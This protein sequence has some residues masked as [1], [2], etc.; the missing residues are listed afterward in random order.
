[1]CLRFCILLVLTALFSFLSCDLQAGW[2]GSCTEFSLRHFEPR[3]SWRKR[4]GRGRTAKGVQDRIYTNDE[5]SERLEKLATRLLEP[6]RTT[7]TEH[8]HERVQELFKRKTYVAAPAGARKV[9][10][11]VKWLIL[12]QNVSLSVPDNTALAMQTTKPFWHS[13]LL[14]TWDLFRSVALPNLSIEIAQCLHD[15]V[16]TVR[17]DSQLAKMPR[18]VEPV[19]LPVFSLIQCRGF[20]DDIPLPVFEAGRP[21][22]RTIFSS[23]L[24]DWDVACALHGSSAISWAH[25]QSKAVFRGSSRKSLESTRITKKNGR[26]RMSV[27]GR[28]ALAQ[29]THRHSEIFDV[30]VIGSSTNCSGRGFMSV[31]EQTNFKYSIYAEG[32][33]GWADRLWWQMHTPQ[34]VL[35]Q[36]SLCGLFFEQLM[37]PFVDH[38]PCA[39]TFE[40]LPHRVKWLTRHDREALIITTNAM[41]FSEAFLVRRAIIEYFETLLK[42]YSEIWC[43]SAQLMGEAR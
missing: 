29:H 18:Y 5:I 20:S 19:P 35:K 10:G 28:E 34:V 38:I 13:R 8:I 32:N 16:Q 39:A 6:L 33:C 21:S 27:Y 11:C 40:D 43:K 31:R 25:R 17:N 37:Q 26:D 15:C 9:D 4:E 1:M 36:E 42:Q 24:I 14:W 2:Q 7:S 22:P 3:L 41:R 23:G 30:V 12:D